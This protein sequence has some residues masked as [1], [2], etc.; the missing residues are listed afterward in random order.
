[1]SIEGFEIVRLWAWMGPMLSGCTEK[2]PKLD[3]VMEVVLEI[4]IAEY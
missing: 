1:M 4:S 3:A 2:G